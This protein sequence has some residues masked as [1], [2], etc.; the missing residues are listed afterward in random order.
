M[1]V[2]E[3]QVLIT[4]LSVD[5]EVQREVLKHLEHSKSAAQRQLNAIRDPMAAVAS[6][7]IV[8][9]LVNLCNAWTDIALSTSALL[10]TIHMDFP[11]VQILNTWL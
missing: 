5:I 10:A 3:L 11:D 8:I 1:S 6:R 2:E 4:K 9:L 7:D